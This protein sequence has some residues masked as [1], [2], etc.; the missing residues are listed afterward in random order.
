MI[1]AR[2]CAV[3]VA[4]KAATVGRLG[5][6]AITGA[7]LRYEGRK[8]CPHWETQC[9]SSTTTR[10]ISMERRN[11]AKPSPSSRSGAT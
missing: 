3:A 5:S 7:M 11:S 6:E 8:S 9:A 4:V 10:P 1:S 2:T